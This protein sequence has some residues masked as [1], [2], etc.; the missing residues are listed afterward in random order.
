MDDLKKDTLFIPDF[1]FIE[2]SSYSGDVPFMVDKNKEK[3]NIK[4]Y[5]N[6]KNFFN[7]YKYPFKIISSNELSDKLINSKTPF[8]YFL[9]SVNYMGKFITIVNS[10]NGEN[11]YATS[12]TKCEYKGLKDVLADNVTEIKLCSEDVLILSEKMKK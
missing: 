12:S 3:K 9:Y 11:V 1:A 8:F 4:E 6:E 7:N 5:I 2:Y 10:L